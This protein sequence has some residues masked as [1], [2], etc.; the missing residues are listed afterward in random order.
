MGL[1]II[2]N[3]L[4][5]IHVACLIIFVLVV[6][7]ELAQLC[8]CFKANEVMNIILNTYELHVTS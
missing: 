5:W 6:P 7:L 2:I 8:G 3:S 4:Q 1:F